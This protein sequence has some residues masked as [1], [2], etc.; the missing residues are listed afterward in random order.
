[1]QVSLVLMNLWASFGSCIFIKII[2][3]HKIFSKNFLEQQYGF[4]ADLHF[5]I[6]GKY[7]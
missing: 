5:I 1:M 2:H 4:S 6:A 3:L 7:R